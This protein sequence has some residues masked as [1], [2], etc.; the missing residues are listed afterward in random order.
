MKRKRINICFYQLFAYPLFN[1]QSTL[2][3]GGG[4]LQYALLAKELAKD[5]QYDVHFVLVGDTLKKEVRNGVTL[6]KVA[7]GSDKSFLSK[8][9]ALK[10]A[11]ALVKEINPDIL[12]SG[13]GGIP[14]FPAYKAAQQCCAKIIGRIG[15][16]TSV[17]KSFIRRAPLSTRLSYEWQVA[18]CDNIIVQHKEQQKLLRKNFSVEGTILRNMI[19]FPAK[20]NRKR[21]WILWVGRLVKVKRPE[22]FI[23]LAKDFPDEQFVMIAPGYGDDYERRIRKE[24]VATPNISF[25]PHVPYHKTGKFFEEAKVFVNT[26][27]NKEG[28][29]NTFI[30]AMVAK[31]PILSFVFNPE[32]MI[33]RHKLGCAAK[34]KYSLMKKQLKELLRNKTKWNLYSKNIHQYGKQHYDI[35][36]GIKKFKNIIKNTLSCD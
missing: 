34:E 35:K 33:T 17:D 14:S 31:T 32:E 6:H 18:S 1:R 29:P 7:K 26:S 28:F 27:E 16:A 10:K 5:K 13:P 22:L 3:F 30:Q 24:A 25:I 4:E 19:N 36:Q 23:R 8:A 2:D 12:V 21:K 20:K 9:L 15:T 11:Y